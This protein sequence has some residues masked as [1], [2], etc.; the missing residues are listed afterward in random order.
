MLTIDCR[1]GEKAY[2]GGEQLI[3][4]VSDEVS[5]TRMVECR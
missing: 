2:L 5:R 3:G 1:E 4:E